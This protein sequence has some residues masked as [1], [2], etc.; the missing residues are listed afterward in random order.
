[1]SAAERANS[2][3]ERR[4]GG[5]R[6]ALPPVGVE[7]LAQGYVEIGRRDLA[8]KARVEGAAALNKI[9]YVQDSTDVFRSIPSSEVQGLDEAS[10]AKYAAL[11]A[12]LP[13]L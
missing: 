5:K 13:S 12:E 10:R 1:M 11:R 3:A 2:S 9:G 8:V 7:K 6:L 4:D